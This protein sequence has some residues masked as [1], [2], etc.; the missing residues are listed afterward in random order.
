MNRIARVAL[1][2][3]ALALPIAMAQPP[4][5]DPSFDWAIEG[6]GFYVSNCA[7]CH[8]QEGAGVPSAF[9]PLAGHVP[10]LLEA[11]DGRALLID[12][13]L[14]GLEGSIEV[15]GAQYD[16]AMPAWPEASDVEI[17][18]V[19]NHIVTSWENEASLPDDFL[20]Y[21]PDDVAERREQD[22]D[23]ADMR[24]R[25]ADAL[26][27]ELAVDEASGDP[28][29]VFDDSTGYYTPAQAE[30]GRAAYEQHCTSCHATNLRGF[31]NPP[32]TGLAFFRDWEGRSM[33]TLFSYIQ[34]QMPLGAGGSLSNSTV[35]DLLAYWME[36]HDYPAGE[37]ALPSAPAVLRTIDVEER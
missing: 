28:V 36:F 7:S 6:F 10:S 30:S 3:L 14:Y 16:G 15:D 13:I 34:S 4:A 23:P 21:A 32:L 24:S 5:S 26:G 2:T 29:P 22:L 27:I 11:D 20:L 12:T 17:A 35:T 18:A 8:G 19:L 1:S 31:H 33:H 25:R 9:P 37:S